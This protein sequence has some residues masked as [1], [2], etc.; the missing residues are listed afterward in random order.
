M[1]YIKTFEELTI[2]EIDYPYTKEEYHKIIYYNFN[3]FGYNFLVTFSKSNKP[4]I[5][6]V[7]RNFETEE[8]GF[9]TLNISNTS[10]LKIYSI[11]TKI[12]S[13]YIKEYNPDLIEISHT[14]NNRYRLNKL[15]LQKTDIDGYE[16]FGLYYKN[17]DK[18]K[19]IILKTS[20]YDDIINLY[21]SDSILIEKIK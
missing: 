16:S 3:I 18:Y 14:T 12:T 17:I 15:F 2:E 20:L 6:I 21:K 10:S 4:G 5:K 8:K 19:T 1:K 9:G 13:D 7:Y 11:I